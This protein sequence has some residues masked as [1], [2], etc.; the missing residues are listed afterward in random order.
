MTNLSSLKNGATIHVS[1][2]FHI[3]H[4]PSSILD[5]SNSF[6]MTTGLFPQEVIINLNASCQ[7][8]RFVLEASGL[9]LAEIYLT[10]DQQI[11][12]HTNWMAV[13][14][15]SGTT[16]DGALESFY[17]EAS[18]LD[19][20]ISATHIRLRILSGIDPFVAIKQLI[21]TGSVLSR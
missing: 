1:T 6:F 12:Q 7:I 16:S 2:S 11:S 5:D 9:S 3:D 19:N 17:S 21:T 8:E 4:P 13:C 18:R 15:L 14:E 10:D 20:P